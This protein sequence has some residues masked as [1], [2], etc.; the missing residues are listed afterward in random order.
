MHLDSPKGELP[1]FNYDKL[2]IEHVLPTKWK[3]HWAID[4]RTRIVCVF[5]IR[6]ETMRRTQSGT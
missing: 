6:S 1:I 2:Q 4:N 5:W 3:E